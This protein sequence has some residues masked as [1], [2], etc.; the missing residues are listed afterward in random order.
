MSASPTGPSCRRASGPAR[1]RTRT[2][3]GAGPRGRA[4]GSRF[5][6]AVGGAGSWPVVD[7]PARVEMERRVLHEAELCRAGTRRQ[8]LEQPAVR[9][10]VGGGQLLEGEG[11]PHA[12]VELVEQDVH[13]AEQAVLE[14][15]VRGELLEAAM[16]VLPLV[17][18]VLDGDGA[19]LGSIIG[20]GSRQHFSGHGGWISAAMRSPSS[21]PGL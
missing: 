13:L 9:V 2:R 4:K 16:A 5:A 20:S 3:S 19:H 1:C 6:A 21:Y 7:G 10:L 11:L 17:A 18:R 12:P 15:R 14:R 8:H